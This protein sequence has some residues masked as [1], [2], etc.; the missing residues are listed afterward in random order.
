MRCAGGIRAAHVFGG[1]RSVDHATPGLEMGGRCDRDPERLQRRERVPAARD[2][3]RSV[4][5][6]ARNTPTSNVSVVTRTSRMRRSRS[7]DGRRAK[8]W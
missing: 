1:P 8:T 2:L 4:S 3:T 6:I 7:S 5:E